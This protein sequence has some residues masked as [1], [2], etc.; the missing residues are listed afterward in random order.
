VSQANVAKWEKN[1]LKVPGRMCAAL[2]R[3]APDEDREFWLLQAGVD[4]TAVTSGAAQTRE[5]P[6][7]RDAAAA[8][9]PRAIDPNEFE[10][11][12]CLPPAM[13]PPGGKLIGLRIEG[14]SMTPVLHTG[15]IV[16]V[17]TTKHQM[18]ALVGKMVAARDGDGVTIK[19]L[20][21][22]GK[23]YLLVPQNTS[24]Q[25]EVRLVTEGDDV[26]IIGEVVKWIGE[27]FNERKRR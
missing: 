13:L 11:T 22:Q 2:S 24:P 16:L 7:L 10:Y 4:P 25:H 27:P 6:V 21:K 18:S 15:F 12:V 9:T 17:D 23:V 3:I 8:G 26:E 5:I 1:K 20:R 19:W 14:E